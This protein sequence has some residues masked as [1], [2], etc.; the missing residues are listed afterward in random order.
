MDTGA[1]LGVTTVLA[2]VLVVTA[3]IVVGVVSPG[4]VLVVTTVLGAVPPEDVE[5]VDRATLRPTYAKMLWQSRELSL[6][7]SL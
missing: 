5:L 1:V 7:A 6:E 4:A 2:G 3:G